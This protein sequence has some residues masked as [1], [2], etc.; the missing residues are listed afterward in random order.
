MKLFTLCLAMCASAGA[1]D[2]YPVDWGKLEPEIVE[3][4]R[5]LLRI[6]TSNPPGNESKAASAIQAMLEREGIATRQF[7]LEPARANLVARIKGTG[8]KRPIL[9]MGHTDV[10]GVQREKWSV[11]PFAAVLKDGVIWG[12]GARDDKP[13]VVAGIMTLLM[14]KRL[15]VN[16]HRC[17]RNGNGHRRTGGGNDGCVVELPPNA[18]RETQWIL[19]D[20][21][22]QE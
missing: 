9:L 11:D 12:R 6:D 22:W 21:I 4:F 14:L 3:R 15:H 8:A 10:V 20:V 16:K 17:G 13:H 5:Q 19:P 18:R 1:Q 7:A 2:R